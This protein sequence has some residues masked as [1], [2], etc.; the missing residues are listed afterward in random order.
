MDGNQRSERRSDDVL[1]EKPAGSGDPAARTEQARQ[2]DNRRDEAIEDWHHD[3]RFPPAE[4][5]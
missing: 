3:H 1:I 4:P 2:R 5:S